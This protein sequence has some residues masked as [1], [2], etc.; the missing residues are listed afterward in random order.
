MAGR[1]ELPQEQLRTLGR[2]RPASEGLGLYLGGGT[3]I[4]IHLGHRIS[5]DLDLFSRAADLDLESVRSTLVELPN[6]EVTSVTDATLAMLVDTIPVDVVRYP[7][8]LLNPTTRGPEEFPV[9]SLV[10]LATMKLSAAARRG[11]RRDFWDLYEIFQGAVTLD[12]ALACY[13][14][15]RYGVKEADL[16]HVI[17]SLTFFDDAEADA[18]LPE[19][20]VPERWSEIKNWFRDAAPKALR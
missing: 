9:A 15:R 5:R 20:L 12:E 1:I 3:A 4:A 17:R 7:Y 6:S 19:G 16:Y 11:I 10:D 14:R 2:L 18:L 8:P 13:V